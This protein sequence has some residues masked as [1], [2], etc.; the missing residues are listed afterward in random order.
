M[1]NYEL[2]ELVSAAIFSLR[3]GRR[4]FVHCS[5]RVACAMRWFKIVIEFCINI[6][7]LGRSD[8]LESECCSCATLNMCS[9]TC[10][11]QPA[12]S[13]IPSNLN[14]VAPD[15]K[16]TLFYIKF[17]ASSIASSLKCGKWCIKLMFV[18]KITATTQR[19]RSACVPLDHLTLL[20]TKIF[21]ADIPPHSANTHHL[22]YKQ[23]FPSIQMRRRHPE[24]TRSMCLKLIYDSG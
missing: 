21:S 3:D 22:L 7:V 14:L 8:S 5:V 17:T 18:L 16:L 12:R 2:F 1:W 15:H 20:A 13:G 6:G 4:T 10:D 19:G 11:E 23:Q 24:E 9:L